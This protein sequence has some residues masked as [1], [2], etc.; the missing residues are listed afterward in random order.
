MMREMEVIPS[1]VWANIHEGTEQLVGRIQ[2][3]G[4][5]FLVGVDEQPTRFIVFTSPTYGPVGWLQKV[6]QTEQTG[7]FVQIDRD[8]KL[9]YWQAWD[10]AMNYAAHLASEQILENII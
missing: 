6:V 3:V 1:K 7:W 4:W 2:G 8:T 5:E 9:G 10:E